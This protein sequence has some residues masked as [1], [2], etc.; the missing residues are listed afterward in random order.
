MIRR[1]FLLL[2]VFL[3]F[4]LYAGD[5]ITACLNSSIADLWNLAGGSVDV[6]VQEAVDRGYASPDAIIIDSASG[7]NI[8]SEKL[9][10][11]APDLILGSVD[12]SSHVRLKS[13]MDSIGW[14]MILIRQDS[15]Q[16]FLEVLKTLADITGRSDL[17]E[18]YGLGQ[19]AEIDGIIEEC[20]EEKDIPHV[21]FIRAGNAFSAV[22]AKRTEDHF[23]TGIINDLGAVNAADEMGALTD[24]LSLEAILKARIDKILIVPQGDEEASIDY[25]RY[26]FSQPGWK[27]VPA[28]ESGEIYFLPKDLFHFKP[29]GRWA[30]AYRV[31]A[32]VLY[33]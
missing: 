1:L 6:T 18:K 22:R 16:D 2:S 26:L 21:L 14:N 30:E 11:A 15:F 4:Q 33:G 24:T 23:A 10:E 8:S 3:S 27:D 31:M 9:I 20:K 17:Y 12:T 19:E 29:N 5:L 32:E 25:V 7:R 28:I 13:F